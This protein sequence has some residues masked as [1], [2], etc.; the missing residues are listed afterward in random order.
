VPRFF[1]GSGSKS[2]TDPE[3]DAVSLAAGR[4]FLTELVKVGAKSVNKYTMI[5]IHT[6]GGQRRRRK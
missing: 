1:Q 3:K 4:S 6:A 2:S 5:S